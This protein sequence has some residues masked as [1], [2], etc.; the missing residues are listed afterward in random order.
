MKKKLDEKEKKEAKKDIE[1]ERSSVLTFKDKK[2]KK[3]KE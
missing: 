2:S 3:N 1:G